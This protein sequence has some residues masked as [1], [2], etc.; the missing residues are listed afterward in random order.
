[1]KLRLKRMGGIERDM[2]IHT[3]TGEKKKNGFQL[4]SYIPLSV[5]HCSFKKSWSA[6]P[7]CDVTPLQL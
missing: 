1:M 6:Q 7:V 2:C 3:L 5:H 4:S